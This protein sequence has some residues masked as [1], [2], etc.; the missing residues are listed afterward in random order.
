VKVKTVATKGLL[1]I[2]V[3]T[4]K[5]GGNLKQIKSLR[6]TAGH[7][8]DHFSLYAFMMYHPR[9]VAFHP[10]KDSE[11]NLIDALRGF[12]FFMI[13][14]GHFVTGP[15]RET[16]R[17]FPSFMDR[18]LMHASNSVIVF[19][20]LSGFLILHSY[21]RSLQ[22][23]PSLRVLLIFYVKRIFRIFPAWIVVLTLSAYLAEA[24]LKTYLWNFFFL[25]GLKPFALSDLLVIQSWS[26]Y[27]EEVFYLSFPFLIALYRK[28]LAVYGLIVFLVAKIFSEG[29][30]EVPPHLTF[31]TPFNTFQFFLC[32]M[33]AYVFIPQ[34]RNLKLSRPLFYL[35]LFFVALLSCIYR[36]DKLVW[37]YITASFLI[38]FRSPQ[39][40]AVPFILVF[41]HLGRMC[42]S[43]YLVHA[44][45][46]PVG[47]RLSKALF[48]P[49]ASW[50]S[51]PLLFQFLF[52]LV[53]TVTTASALYFLVERPLM[54][55]GADRAK[56]WFAGPK[57]IHP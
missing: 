9:P 54:I 5:K 26:L 11:K 52:C 28:N 3:I 23:L 13:F 33:F 38:L 47:L 27:V 7:A 14:L 48:A 1:F 36:T 19:F 39:E 29:T 24:D 16:V 15:I 34:W 35:C 21:S 46:F 57:S 4:P 44:F 20:A 56:K 31:N 18:A 43:L 45:S 41:K 8:P 2:A 37:C 53:M 42:Y 17:D 25:F 49:P 32:G 10:L 55:Y 50:I 6:V 40:F 51:L 30:I 12:L 22:S